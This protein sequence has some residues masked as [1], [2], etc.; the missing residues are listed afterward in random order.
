MKI[1]NNLLI[2]FKNNNTEKVVTE[3]MPLIYKHSTGISLGMREDIIQELILTC[4]SVTQRYDFNS[5]KDLSDYIEEK[6][7]RRYK[8]NG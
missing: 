6:K 1:N 5:G 3:L 4:I 8:K 2:A 7:E